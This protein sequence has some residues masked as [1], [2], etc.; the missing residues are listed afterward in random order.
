VANEADA[1]LA[2]LDLARPSEADR[3]VSADD[4][5]A[6]AADLTKNGKRLLSW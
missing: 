3:L 6:L 2:A 1:I 5:A 4:A